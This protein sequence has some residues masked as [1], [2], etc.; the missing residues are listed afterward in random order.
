ME[1]SLVRKTDA[2]VSENSDLLIVVMDVVHDHVRWR[3][4]VISFTIVVH[5]AILG[6]P[7]RLH[8]NHFLIT[9]CKAAWGWE[10]VSGDGNVGT[11]IQRLD[12]RV[13]SLCRKE[14]CI[15]WSTGGN[16]EWSLPGEAWKEHKNQI[17]WSL[18]FCTK[19]FSL[20]LVGQ[21][22]IAEEF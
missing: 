18:R 12:V 10:D 9:I 5:S 2:S 11:K 1:L 6:L 13:H 4:V 16:M 19:E 7:G 8:V 3:R 20:Y 21:W 22:R 15:G 14:Q 17:G